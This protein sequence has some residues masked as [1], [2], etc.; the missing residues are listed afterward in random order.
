[1]QRMVNAADDEDD[2]ETMKRKKSFFSSNDA[3]VLPSIGVA[4]GA[5]IFSSLMCFSLYVV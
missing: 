2:E 5:N 4:T 1:M 3:A